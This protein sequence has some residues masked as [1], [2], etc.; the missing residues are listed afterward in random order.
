MFFVQGALATTSTQ[1]AAAAAETLAAGTARQGPF[2][3]RVRVRE[4]VS[5]VAGSP[6]G[7]TYTINAVFK[8]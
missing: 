5:G 4:K 8:R 6:T 3:D 2:C 7:V 1:G